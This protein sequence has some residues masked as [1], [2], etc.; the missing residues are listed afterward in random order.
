GSQSPRNMRQV[1]ADE[2]TDAQVQGDSGNNDALRPATDFQRLIRPCGQS[3]SGDASPGERHEQQR[4]EIDPIDVAIRKKQNQTRQAGQRHPG[5][6]G[7]ADQRLRQKNALWMKRADQQELQGLTLGKLGQSPA[8]QHGA[9][10][11]AGDE[12]QMTEDGRT[13]AFMSCRDS[14]SV[15]GA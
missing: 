11:D 6:P 5:Q 10:N 12:Q 14:V 7:Y 9:F 4:E 1:L 8:D 13:G 3:Q 15:E 2:D